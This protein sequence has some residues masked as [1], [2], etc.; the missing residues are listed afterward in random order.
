MDRRDASAG[1]GRTCIVGAGPAGLAVAI[2]LA[3]EGQE[4]TVVDCARPPIDK[5]CGEGLLPDS[6]Q[7]LKQLGIEIPAGAGFAFHGIRFAD[8]WS[9]VS[10]DFPGGV[11]IGIRRTVLHD[12][13]VRETAKRGISILW[14]AKH[15]GLTEDGVSADGRDIKAWLVVGA[16]GQNSL[17]RRQAGL[18]RTSSEKR[19][20]GFRRHYRVTPWS[21]YMELYWT[22]RA[23]VYVTPVATDEVCVAVISRDSKLRVADVLSEI[24]ELQIRLAGSEPVSAE[25]GA[26]SVS[27]KLLNV[28]RGTLVLIGDASGSVDAITGEGMGV[29]FKQALA[30]ARVL[31]V[32]DIGMYEEFHRQ[33]MRRPRTMASLMLLLERNSQLQRRALAGLARQ[34]KVFES[35]L[36]I[37]VGAASFRDLWS[38]RLLDFGWAFLAE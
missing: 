28:Q 38:P 33:L 4:V 13:L 10:A 8:P 7:A 6:I 14:G 20:Y 32:S 17:V 11:G 12:L 24:P 30:L 19:R 22:P 37:H 25:K 5:T 16:D 3:C 29:A 18:G 21:R 27:R 34:P 36:A 1:A 9:S 31:E 23:Q 2:A 26:L 15:V 35:L